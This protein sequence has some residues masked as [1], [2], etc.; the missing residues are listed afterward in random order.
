MQDRSEAKIVVIATSIERLEKAQ[1]NTS[2]IQ[3]EMSSSLAVMASTL[4]KIEGSTVS[5][6]RLS[7]RLNTV[8]AL[9]DKSEKEHDD[10]FNTLREIQSIGSNSRLKKLE[11]S[12]DAY[13]ELRVGPRLTDVEAFQ[14]TAIVGTIKLIIVAFVAAV[15]GGSLRAFWGC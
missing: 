1:K 11:G 14:K 9:F 4:Q 2:D 5:I 7:G 6:E 8:S 15:L 12:V 10:I 13:T 3:V